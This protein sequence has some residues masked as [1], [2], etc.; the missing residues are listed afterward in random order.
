MA[1]EEQ[2]YI[3]WPLLLAFVWK[4]KW[5]F[6][7]ITATITAVSF[8]ANIYATGTDASAAFFLPVPRFWELMAGSLLAYI[9]LH[10][11]HLLR[12]HQSMQSI[13]GLAFLAIGMMCIN[14]ERAFPGWWALLPVL[15][16]VLIISAGSK[17]WFNSRI[18]S[19]RILV[20]FGL[21]SYPL[22]LWHWPLLSFA[23]MLDGETPSL[24]VRIGIVIISVVLAWA[25]FSFVEKPIRFGRHGGAKI[26]VMIFL[27]LVMG[28]AGYLGFKKNGFK[29]NSGFGRIDHVEQNKFLDYFNNRQPE[30][31]YFTTLKIPEKWRFECDFYNQEAAKLLH[32]TTLPLPEIDSSCYT[33]NMTY[34]HAVLI[35]GD[36]NSQQLS[37]G[38]KNN[39]PDSWQLLDTS[40]SGCVAD[41][42]VTEPSTKNWCNQS[43]WFAL[44]TIRK[45][46]PDVVIVSQ[47]LE[48][49]LKQFAEIKKN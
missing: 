5:S 11:P 1:V 25:T 15:G 29:G 21:I 38:L 22:Y 12:Q 41:P 35:W 39:L 17:A 2:F 19:N 7:A 46:K 20:W 33:R 24:L 10:K 42:D 8:A 28:G 40:S 6:V 27:M 3:F 18:L 32:A 14:R 49:N 9:D 47:N 43:N 48:H 26:T 4:R 37:F 34:K 44:K 36:S 16:A 23:T 45:A 13:L 31:N 30:M